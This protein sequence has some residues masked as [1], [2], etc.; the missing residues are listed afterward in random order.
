MDATLPAPFHQLLAGVH[1]RLLARSHPHPRAGSHHLLGARNYPHLLGQYA[2]V[3]FWKQ[4]IS[5][6]FFKLLLLR[7]NI[8]VFRVPK[9]LLLSYILYHL[10]CN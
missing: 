9:H 10:F 1:P 6:I 5:V 3:H 7:Q 4:N 2:R 8:P